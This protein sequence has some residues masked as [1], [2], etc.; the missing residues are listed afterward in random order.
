MAARQSRR[1]APAPPSLPTTRS[2]T[3]RYGGYGSFRNDEGPVTAVTGP[4]YVRRLG[5][6]A[7][8]ADARRPSDR[9]QRRGDGS[10]VVVDAD[11]GLR[12]R[13]C[14]TAV[15]VDDVDLRGVAGRLGA[16]CGVRLRVHLRQPG[17]A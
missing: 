7:A 13:P 1:R 6:S 14:G 5:G 3:D 12:V 8:G 10:Q 2:S 17:P 4:S 15:G 16:A 11:E 9:A